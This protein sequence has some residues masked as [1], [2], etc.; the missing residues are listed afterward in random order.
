MRSRE[1]FFSLV[2]PIRVGCADKS[3]VRICIFHRLMQRIFP[4]LLQNI[5][6]AL[7]GVSTLIQAPLSVF[8]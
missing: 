6:S 1:A 3:N 7:P 4:K 5:F 2:R 8:F